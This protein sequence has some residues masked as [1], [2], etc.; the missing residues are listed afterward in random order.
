MKNSAIN[1]NPL[2]IVVTGLPGSGKSTYGRFLAK[3]FSFAYFDYDTVI[4]NFMEPLFEKYYSNLSYKEC[5]REW[6]DSCYGSLWDLSME[7]IKLGNSVIASAPL[8]LEKSNEHFF[9]QLKTTYHVEFNVLSVSFNVPKH[10]LKE[11]ISNRNEERDREKLDDWDNYY[12]GQNAAITWDADLNIILNYGKK[13]T[14]DE[15][16]QF[17]A[18]HL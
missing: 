5:S 12:E 9:K 1:P 7:N 13:D 15:I 3:K 6:R 17:I 10:I 2:L 16:E 14:T 4:H 8:S 18:R 11:R